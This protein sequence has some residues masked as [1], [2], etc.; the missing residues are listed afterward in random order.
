M[1]NVDHVIMTSD[2]N[3]EGVETNNNK[4]TI[5]ANPFK[6]RTPIL[7]KQYECF[8]VNVLNLKLL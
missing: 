3:N 6:E 4:Q 8:Y 2:Y 5:N 1:K 7:L